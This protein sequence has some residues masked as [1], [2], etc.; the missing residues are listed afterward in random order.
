MQ[1]NT[2][3]K[4]SK[5]CLLFILST[6]LLTA[7]SFYLDYKEHEMREQFIREFNTFS[8]LVKMQKEDEKFSSIADTWT[9]NDAPPK[10]NGS[11]KDDY[12]QYISKDRWDY[13]RVLFNK[14]GVESGL[15]R[16]YTL[17]RGE[18]RHV[19]FYLKTSTFGFSYIEK[20]P[21][22]VFKSFRECRAIKF[23]YKYKCYVF[24]K[25]K[26]YLHMGVNNEPPQS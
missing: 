15:R 1:L 26:W 13:Y 2:F 25:E 18:V 22:R 16:A 17:G 10:V 6:S 5:V 3:Y 7:C 12:L 20:P 9:S 8:L 4:N 21:A 23:D 11:L 14:A 24:L 19:K